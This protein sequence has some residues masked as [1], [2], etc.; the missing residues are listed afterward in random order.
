MTFTFISPKAIPARTRSRSIRALVEGGPNA[1]GDRHVI[2]ID[3][4]NFKLYELFNA[5]ISGGGWKADSGAIFDLKTGAD[6]PLGWTSA[7]AAGLPIFAGL[8][9]YDEVMVR[10]VINHALRITASAT[11]NGFIH[12][13][14]HAAGSANSALP[15]MGLRLRLK[16]DYDISWAS[17]PVRVV[18]TALKKYGAIVADN[19]SS[20][21]IGGTPDPRWNDQQLHDLSSSARQRV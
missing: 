5:S 16:A 11:Q 3:R 21:F 20:W 1:T 8:V 18:L 2:V 14:R 6:R 10:G 13:A 17:A 4:D 9:R 12:P 15:P 7:D 19:G